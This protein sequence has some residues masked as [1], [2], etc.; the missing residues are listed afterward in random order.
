MYIIRIKANEDGS[1]PGLQSW[2]SANQP[3]GYAFCD[4]EQMAVFYSTTPAGFVD[5]TIKEVE[6]Y[7]VV[8]TIAVNQAAVDAWVEAHPVLP[9]PEPEPT[10]LDK[11]EAQVTYSAMMNGTLIEEAE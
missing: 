8:D 7:K 3:D 9:E 4:D 2:N 5:I 11:I 6:G 1:R 10:Q